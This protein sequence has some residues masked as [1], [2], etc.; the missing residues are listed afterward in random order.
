MTAGAPPGQHRLAAPSGFGY[1]R[2]LVYPIVF[3]LGPITIYSFG[4]MLATAFLVAGWVVQR[5]LARKGLDPEAASSFVLWAA[6]GG[7]VGS[8]LLSFLDDWRGF[9]AD[10]VGAIFSGAGFVF[11]G[12][13]LTVSIVIWRRGMPWLKVVDCIAPGLAIGQAIGRIGCQLA[14]DGDWGTPST[15]P[16]A[17]SYPNAIIGWEE[18]TRANG[19]PPDVRV[20]PAP[21]YETLAYGA[22]FLA[23]WRL[24]RAR[25]ADGVV[26]WLYLVLSGAARFLVEIVRVNPRL[27]YGLTEAQLISLALIAFGGVMIWRAAASGPLGVA[28]HAGSGEPPVR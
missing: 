28:A 1:P 18:W 3:S 19:L 22:V 27:A 24:R 25:H 9:V 20:H 26:L 17:M 14:G 15:L 6:V 5:E 10:P 21:I 12:G 4:V 11:Y 13:L 7:L 2:G 16:W 23:L 8:R